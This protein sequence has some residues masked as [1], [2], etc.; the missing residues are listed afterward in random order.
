MDVIVAA[1]V[2]YDGENITCPQRFTSMASMVL[3]A[4][5]GIKI[6]AEDP[7]GRPPRKRLLHGP[8]WKSQ[9]SF[10]K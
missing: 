5:S 6:S 9:T 7:I 1:D 4:D 10:A 8:T 2:L 3:V